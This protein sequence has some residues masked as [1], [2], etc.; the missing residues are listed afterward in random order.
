MSQWAITI[1]QDIAVKRKPVQMRMGSLGVEVMTQTELAHPEIAYSADYLAMRVPRSSPTGL[2][3]RSSLRGAPGVA[4]GTRPEQKLI[5]AAVAEITSASRNAC[6]SI[7]A[8]HPPSSTA[9]KRRALL[10]LRIP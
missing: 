10:R 9:T 4:A 6:A 5:R 7:G 2:K 1:C 8:T 3:P